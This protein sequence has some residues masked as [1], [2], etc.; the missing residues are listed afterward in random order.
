MVGQ[1]I[2]LGGLL[3]PYYDIIAVLSP[4]S[5]LIGQPWAGPD[6][7]LQPYQILKI[8][9]EM[10]DDF[11]YFYYVISIKDAYR[12]W[13]TVTESD[14]AVLDPQR[15]QQGQTYC[16]V[17]RDYNPNFGGTIGPVIPVAATGTAP[18]STTTFGFSY[19]SDATYILQVTTGGAAG[20]AAF[21]WMRS[22]QTAFTGP[23]ITADDGSPMDL[24]DGVQV[25]FPTDGTYTSGDLFVINAQSQILTGNP[26]VELW[27]GPTYS[28]YLYPYQYLCKEYDITAQQPQLPPFVANRG[29]VLLEMALAACARYPGPD[30]DHPSPY[31]NL[32]LAI[33]HDKRCEQ[34]LDDMQRNDEELSLSNIWYESY[35]LY[36][37]P[38]ADGSYQA[39][40]APF[41]NG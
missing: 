8:Y 10:P 16:A 14:V 24:Q 13:T 1:Q 37:A 4:T 34:L 7:A 19:I 33:L 23:I 25:Y 5:I 40:H 39:H 28:G 2:R 18:V 32:N 21:Q 30:M 6:V 41:M 26:R 20:T 15:T 36:P 11:G 12:L 22:G 38:W 9:Y 27:P 29:E 17:F 35:P 3:Y 31:F